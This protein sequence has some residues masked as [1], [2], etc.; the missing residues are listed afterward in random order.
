MICRSGVSV[1]GT[2][3]GGPGLPEVRG[4]A[5]EAPG[6][7]GLAHSSAGAGPGSGGGG[8]GGAPRIV[9]GACVECGRLESLL[10]SSA[11]SERPCAPEEEESMTV[12]LPI[13]V[14]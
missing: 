9:V 13:S 7:C 5:R 1:A 8:T 6:R 4:A 12:S 10:D 2:L 11:G 14:W 3:S